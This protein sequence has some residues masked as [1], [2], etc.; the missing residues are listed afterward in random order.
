MQGEKMSLS[1][2][3]FGSF[4]GNSIVDQHYAAWE[5]TR[6]EQGAAP[7]EAAPVQAELG[8]PYTD[9]LASAATQAALRA[10]TGD[11]RR[12]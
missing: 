2:E 9:L 7:V 12:F 8:N 6:L 11:F 5:A 3:S 10:A 1:A 4:G